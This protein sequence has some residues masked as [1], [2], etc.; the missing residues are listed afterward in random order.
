MLFKAIKFILG[1]VCF[2]SAYLIFMALSLGYIN[3]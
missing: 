2:I 1:V 3:G